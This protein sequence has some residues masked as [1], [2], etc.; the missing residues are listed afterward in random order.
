MVI[1][2]LTFLRFIV[3]NCPNIQRKQKTQQE[4]TIKEQRAS[5]FKKKSI[6][7]KQNAYLQSNR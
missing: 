6:L 4:V 1:V 3:S 7:L 2:K 5:L